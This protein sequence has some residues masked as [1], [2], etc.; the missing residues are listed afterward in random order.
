MDL[1]TLPS[2]SDIFVDTNIFLYAITDHPKYGDICNNFLDRIKAGDVKGKISVIV[3]NELIHKLIIGEIAEK[4]NIAPIQVIRHIKSNPGLLRNL[5][6]YDTIRDVEANYNLEIAEL[7]KEDFAL[8]RE[9]MVEYLLLSNDA[10]HLAVIRRDRIG[11]IATNDPDF[12][13]VKGI[14]VW[15]P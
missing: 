2:A 10:L 11:N 3:L 9:L 8:S 7:R 12:D 13:K 4:K 15:K 14:Q 6:T 1:R 5:E